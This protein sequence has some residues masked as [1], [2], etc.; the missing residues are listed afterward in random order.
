MNPLSPQHGTREGCSTLIGEGRMQHYLI[1]RPLFAAMEI[2]WIQ[3]YTLLLSIMEQEGLTKHLQHGEQS[4]PSTLTIRSQEK[5]P[6][7]AKV[8]LS[9][10]ESSQ[11]LAL[12]QPRSWE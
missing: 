5:D 3:D 11:M 1:L 9:T 12:I 10:L 2:I 8:H 7:N 4:L 6:M